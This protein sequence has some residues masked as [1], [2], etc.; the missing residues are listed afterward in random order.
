MTAEKY[1]AVTKYK[2]MNVLASERAVRNKPA[3]DGQVSIY[4]KLTP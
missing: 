1:T 4:I 2:I 3:K